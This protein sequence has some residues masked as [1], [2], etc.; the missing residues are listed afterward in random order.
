MRPPAVVGGYASTADCRRLGVSTLSIT[1]RSYG[2]GRWSMMSAT[3]RC[4]ALVDDRAPLFPSNAV[5]QAR[6][7]AWVGGAWRPG[8]G[9]TSLRGFKEANAFSISTSSRAS[10]QVDRMQRRRG[11][12]GGIPVMPSDTNRS[13]GWSVGHVRATSSFGG[14]VSNVALRKIRMCR[15]IVKHGL[16]KARSDGGDPLEPVKPASV[17]RARRPR[18][19]RGGGASSPGNLRS[20]S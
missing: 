8:L 6:L 20:R 19:H 2:G 12:S 10:A 9:A 16:R 1:F 4:R 3:R 5:D 15:T 14:E 7:V 17:P 13:P 11:A 18:S